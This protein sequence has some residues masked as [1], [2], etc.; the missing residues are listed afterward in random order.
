MRRHHPWE[1]IVTSLL[2]KHHYYPV[3]SAAPHNPLPIWRPS[4][5]SS[6]PL[7]PSYEPWYSVGEVYTHVFHA[8]AC[9]CGGWRITSDAIPPELPTLYEAG[10]LGLELAD[11]ARLAEQ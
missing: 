8:Y 7:L 9:T 11:E 10:P 1:Q 6:W 4:C 2:V 5:C 3:C